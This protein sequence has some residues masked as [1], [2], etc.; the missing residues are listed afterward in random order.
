MTGLRLQERMIW[1]PL[2]QQVMNQS[3]TRGNTHNHNR[4]KLKDPSQNPARHI[5]TF[6]S[7]LLRYS[8]RRAEIG[9]TLMALR[10]GSQ[11]AAAAVIVTIP[12]AIQA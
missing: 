11:H 4:H 2:L 12:I 10:A 7:P 8:C 1:K 3:D 9:S 5:A 6:T